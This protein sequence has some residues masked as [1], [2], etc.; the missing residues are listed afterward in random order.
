MEEVVR[1]HHIGLSVTDVV[2]SV[3][4][5]RSILGFEVT[6]E[7]DGPTFRRTRLRTPGSG[8]TLTLTQ[9]DEASTEAFTELRAGMDHVAFHV[10]TVEDLRSLKRRFERL[11]V[12]HSELKEVESGIA[13]IT[14][15]DPDNLQLETWGEGR[16]VGNVGFQEEASELAADHR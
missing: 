13:M 3:E 7:V 12:S 5:Y 4:W 9:H 8:L 11:G 15:R 1:F 6:A 14:L 10:G 2:R 16:V